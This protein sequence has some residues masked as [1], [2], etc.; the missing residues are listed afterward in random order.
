MRQ[1]A[2]DILHVVG[3]RPNFPKAA[4]VMAA[5]IGRDV[6]QFLLHTGQHYDD[7]MS[8]VFFRDLDLPRPDQNLGIGS[9]THAEQTAAAMIG[10]ETVLLEQRPRLVVVYGDVNSTLAAAVVAA[11]LQIPLAHVEAGL[12]S[13]DNAMPEEINR[14]VTDALSELLFTTSPEAEDNLLRE[15][16]SK[17]RILFVGNPMI[18]TLLRALPRLGQARLAGEA[19][20][21]ERYCVVTIHRPSNIDDSDAIVELVR[22]LNRLSQSR[23]LVFPIHPR[24]RSRLID[25]GLD[26][27][28]IR[29]SEPL[30]YLDFL[31]LVRG[32]EAVITDSGGIQ[33]ETTILGIPCLTLRPNTER[34]I[35]ISCGTNRLVTFGTVEAELTHLAE[36]QSSSSEERRLVPPL[37]DGRAGER[38][39]DSITAWLAAQAKMDA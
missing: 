18:D 2:V 38:I 3:A 14:R 15:G 33:E 35:T 34:P 36:A 24:G 19:A 9:G 16:V 20:L 21:P 28:R 5:L 13:F 29:V 31:A 8:E 30:G 6:S 27:V 23:Q 25:A 39:A 37:W 26:T 17:D 22:L 12:R 32:S 7:R 1:S 4:P 10:L 11:K